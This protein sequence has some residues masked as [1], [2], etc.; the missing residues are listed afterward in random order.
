M[1][2]GQNSWETKQV[3][4]L[5]ETARQFLSGTQAETQHFHKHPS[6]ISIYIQQKTL[7]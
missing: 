6:E 2:N 7:Q 1:W 4:L 3:P 5:W